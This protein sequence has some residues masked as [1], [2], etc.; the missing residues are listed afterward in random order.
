MTRWDYRSIGK[1]VERM[2][3]IVLKNGT[4]KFLIQSGLVDHIKPDIVLFNIEKK[5]RC[6]IVDF[7]VSWDKIVQKKEQE[8]VDSYGPLAKDITRV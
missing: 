7:S 6:T 1:C 5:G 3:L 8:K 4:V 2:A